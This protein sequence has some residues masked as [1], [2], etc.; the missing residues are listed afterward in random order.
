MTSGWYQSDGRPGHRLR[1]SFAVGWLVL[2]PL[3][4]WFPAG[5][6]PGTAWATALANLFHGVWFLVGALL[7]RRAWSPG[8]AS[9]WL[10]LVAL[11]AIFE[12][13]QHWV[14]YRDPSW[15]DEALNAA[16]AALGVWWPAL[17]PRSSG[18]PESDR[19]SPPSPQGPGA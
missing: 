11:G 4:M 2:S 14:P 10:A 17:L 3:L 7:L 16:G 5:P 1:V 6:E 18:G 15:L 13:V 12:I 8:R 19:V 9:A